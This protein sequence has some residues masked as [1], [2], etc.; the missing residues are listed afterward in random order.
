M[1]EP[2]CPKVCARHHGPGGHAQHG[3][4][5]PSGGA[6]DRATTRGRPR[7][8][9]V[10][11]GALLA[12][13]A[14]VPAC[15]VDLGID[16]HGFASQGYLI[17]T[18]NNY[19]G[20][21]LQD[22]SFE[23]NEVG[24]NVVATPVD[25]LRVGAQVVSLDAGDFGNN[26]V[27]IDWAYGDYQ[28]DQRLGFKLGR[29]KIPLGLANDT[30]D[31]DLT[32]TQVF[33]PQAVYPVPLRDFY[34]AVN[35][36]GIYGTAPMG[37]LGT[38]DYTAYIGGQNITSQSATAR[39]FTS[40]GAGDTFSFIHVSSIEGGA[41]TWNTPADGLRLRA[42]LYHAYRLNV[43]GHT[44]GAATSAAG[45][46][47]DNDIHAQLHDFWSGI[48]SAEYQ[49]KDLTLAGEYLR[50]Y[51]RNDV[52]VTSHPF[53]NAPAAGGPP[54][55]TVRV[56]LPVTTTRRISYLRNEGM[57][58]SAGYRFL[59]RF[60]ASV[61]REIYFDDTQARGASFFRS[62]DLSLRWDILDHW[63]AKAEW[64]HVDGTAF[65]SRQDNPQGLKDSMDVLSLKTTFDF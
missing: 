54:G 14:A 8:F 44:L 32:R 34:I 33:L 27:E 19:L 26:Q 56:D 48:L 10:A 22:G 40:L 18:G 41:L 2:R 59:E 57:Y 63:L 38:L 21:T 64:Q 60:E 6:Q 7:R 17:T 9:Q 25:R 4:P 53:I 13:G 47:S 20:P 35:G 15:A 39:Y 42:S 1:L 65:A 49:W 30:R 61:G 16:L 45:V 24:L 28:L 55:S 58:L 62:W 11:T 12:F 43:L 29:F 52:V 31:L 23:F 36:V 50:N 3:V 5:R 46:F 51:S 37:G